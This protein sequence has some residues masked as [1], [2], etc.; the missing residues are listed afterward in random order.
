MHAACMAGDAASVAT[1][2]GAA[3][4]ALQLA[5]LSL[6]ECVE[7]A[8]DAAT[9][10]A[11]LGMLSAAEHTLKLVAEDLRVA[12]CQLRDNVVSA[13]NDGIDQSLHAVKE[14]ADKAFS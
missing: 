10:P 1:A 13:T 12:H 7:R 9:A 4:H 11:T 6:A 8:K 2:A 3:R 5:G 14:Y